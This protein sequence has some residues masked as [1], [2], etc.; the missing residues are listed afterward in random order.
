MPKPNSNKQNKKVKPFDFALIVTV[1]IMLALGIVMVLS[2]SSPSSLAEGE[3]GYSYVKTQA[4]AALGGLV[5]MYIISK[6]DYRVYKKFDKL[7]YG[8]T[9]LL[10][11]AVLIPGLKWTAG[12]ASR[13]IYIKPLKLTIQ[14]SEIA[15]VALVIFFAS[16]LTDNRDKLGER[17]EGFFKPIIQFL[18]PV[19][20][21][22]VG[23]QSHL[24]AS[25]L[26]IAVISIMMMMAGCKLRYFFGYGS[27][28]MAGAAG[29]MYFMATVLE[30]G[31]YRLSRLTSF[32]DPWAD[33]TGDGWQVI[34]GLYAI[35]SRWAFWSTDL[36][37]ARK[38]IY[39]YQNHK[40][41]L[42]FRSLQK[43]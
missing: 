15:K 19:I 16:Y 29:V 25:I 43:N 34:Q 8:M 38:N 24:S 22:L 11:L 35:G 2:A 12:G 31:A 39:T 17:W 14:P 37:I 6:I 3:D 9:I 28:G 26:I 40:M 1:L 23:V 20:L 36:E 41:T 30:K 42:Y 18:A 13:W 10:L 5:L 33:P 32:L 27:I 7:A 21:I 4:F